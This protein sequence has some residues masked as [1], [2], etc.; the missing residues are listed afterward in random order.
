MKNVVVVAPYFGGNMLHCIRCFAKLDV[1]LGIIT[2]EAE[3]RVPEDLRER[4]AGHYRIGNSGDGAQLTTAIKAF[5]RE[6]G[7]VDRLEGYLEQ[8]QVPIATAREAAGIDGMHAEAAKNFRDKNRMK[9]VLREAGVSVARQAL[10]TGPDDARE[11]VEAVGFPVVLKPLD[12]AGARN[13]VRVVDDDDLF[14]ALER[15]LPSEERPV[16]AEEFVQGEEHT[17][18]TVMIDGNPVWTSSS[19]YLPGPLAVLENPWMQYCILLPREQVEPHVQAFRPTNV[20]ALRA[21]GMH[22]G[23]SHMEWFLTR[24]GR[25]LV[26]EVGARPPG[27]NIMTLNGAAHDTDMWQAWTRLQVDRV[28]EV[29]DRKY[30]AGC[31]F[32]R[33]QGRGARVTRVTGLEK[34]QEQMGRWVFSHKLPQAGAARSSHYEGDGWVIVRH[35]D[36][37]VVVDALR[38]LVTQVTIE[39]G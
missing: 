24:S 28:W 15:L 36:T 23:I 20:A 22:S 7:R 18:E 38:T 14:A 1:R 11:F 16:Q 31:A 4:L 30:A 37:R 8:L 21:L 6:W 12:G 35:P 19:Y 13:T 10:V 9:Q 27:A 3:D 5:Q 17:C 2:H 34:A 29:P 25:S 39:A 33:A 32:L 26:S